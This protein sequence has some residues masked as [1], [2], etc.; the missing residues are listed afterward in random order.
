MSRRIAIVKLGIGQ[1]AFFD[2][3]TNIHL[4]LGQPS[5]E[6]FDYMNTTRIKRAVSNK[7]LNLVTG[8]FDVDNNGCENG[9]VEITKPVQPKIEVKE[10]CDEVPA[11]AAAKSKV[12]RVVEEKVVEEEPTTEQKATEEKVEEV[13]TETKTKRRKKKEE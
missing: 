8:S 4:T 5:A 9:Y 11:K 13:E 2:P 10:K 1:V 12:E 6:I 7:I 3:L